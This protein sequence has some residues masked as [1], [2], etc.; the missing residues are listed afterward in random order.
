LNPA[1]SCLAI[2]QALPKSSSGIY[3]IDGDG[4]GSEAK[5][6]TWCEMK[7]G[8]GGW[9]LIGVVG[10]D[11]RP[12]AWKGGSYPRPGATYYGSTA[13]AALGDIL[14]PA[15][16]DAVIK[17]FSVNGRDLLAASA[18]REVMAYVGGATDDW[19][20]VELPTACNPFNSATTCKE[21][22]MTGLKVVQS[23]GKV[24]S[25]Q[26]QACGGEADSCGYNEFGFHLIDGAESSTCS[27]HNS[28]TGTGSQGIGRIWTSFNRSDGGYWNSGMHSGW[29]GGFNQ[30]GALLV[31]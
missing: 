17:N 31:R 8:G 11:G 18:K 21:G 1:L 27:C 22:T 24:I 5:F 16:N 15:K 29:K 2:L 10:T 7:L 20:T 26:G 28:S 30:P 25:S 23:D 13:G 3:W 4:S 9:T 6:Q 12:S 19:V 14:S